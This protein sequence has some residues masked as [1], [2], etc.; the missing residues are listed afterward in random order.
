MVA[1]GGAESRRMGRGCQAANFEKGIPLEKKELC[2]CT[3]RTAIATST[4]CELSGLAGRGWVQ[5]LKEAG[6]DG[7]KGL[8]GKTRGHFLALNT[9]LRPISAICNGCLSSLGDI[10]PI[11]HMLFG[12]VSEDLTPCV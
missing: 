8:C 6:L 2:Q 1:V 12:S 10:K 7:G 5:R 9:L 11:W 4:E 3:E